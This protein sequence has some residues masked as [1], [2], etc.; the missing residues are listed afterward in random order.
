[1][2]AM[3]QFEVFVNGVRKASLTMDLFST[4]E[5]ILVELR[6]TH[7]FCGRK[8]EFFGSVRDQLDIHT[9]QGL[10]SLKNVSL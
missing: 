2:H 3:H 8:A 4:N 5:E 7:L 1:M 6:K 10:F 9:T